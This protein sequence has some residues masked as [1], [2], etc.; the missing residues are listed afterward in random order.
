VIGYQGEEPVIVK[1]EGVI[2]FPKLPEHQNPGKPVG[3]L[4]KEVS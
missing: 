2:V 4:A 1:E 3:Y